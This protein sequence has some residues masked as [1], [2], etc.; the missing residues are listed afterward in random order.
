MGETIIYIAVGVVTILVGFLAG[1]T[2]RKK[3]AEA[4]IGSAEQQAAR[5]V[6]DAE[7]EADRKKKEALVEAKEEII[8]N[9]NEADREIK[10]RRNEVSSKSA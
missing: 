9:K 3:I 1:F 7:K 6:S 2:Y 8:R 10:E 5:I 4:K